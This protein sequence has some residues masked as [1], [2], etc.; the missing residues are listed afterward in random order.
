MEEEEE[1]EEDW[2][3]SPMPLLILE[4]EGGQCE[5]PGVPPTAFLSTR[6]AKWKELP[7]WCKETPEQR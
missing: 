1:E 2:A 7:R 5:H 4:E 6:R 3:I